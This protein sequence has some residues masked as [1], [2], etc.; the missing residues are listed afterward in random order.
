MAN[1]TGQLVGTFVLLNV[2]SG[3]LVGQS[4]LSYKLAVKMIE[5][6]S[7]GTGKSSAFVSGRV[8][9]TISVGG[10][11]S[12]SKEAT[13]KGFWELRAA[14]VAGA[15]I[16]VTFTEYSD[17]TGVTPVSGAESVTGSA[18]I[19]NLQWDAPDDDKITFSC[20]LQ[21]TGDMTESTT[22]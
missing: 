11:A 21:V 17:E 14:A 10:I 5:T 13:N 20:D 7:K 16:P 19:N 15:A 12:T 18:L 6:S 22:V 4:S 8:N 3:V 1:P 2:D 9:E